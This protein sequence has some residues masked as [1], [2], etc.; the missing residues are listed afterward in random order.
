[1]QRCPLVSFCVVT[2]N[3]ENYIYQ[4]L[5]SIV[6]CNFNFHFEIL[7]GNDKST[8][9]TI[10]EI[11]RF[12]RDFP[13][14]NV[15]LVDRE[16]NVGTNKNYLDLFSKSKGKYF[17][18]LD[19]DDYLEFND[20]SINLNQILLKSNSC[21]A[22][23]YKF[24][25]EVKNEF[26]KVI[27]KDIS[28]EKSLDGLFFHMSSVFFPKWIIDDILNYHW[29]VKYNF[30]DRP[31]QI[32]LI[33]DENKLFFSDTFMSVYRMHINS[34]SKKMNSLEILDNVSHFLIDYYRY[35][36]KRFKNFEKRVFKRRIY[37]NYIL[38][39]NPKNVISF[40][41]YIN[42]LKNDFTV[43]AKSVSYFFALKIVFTSLCL[44]TL[45]KCRF[46]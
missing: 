45:K 37:N 8:D 42:K 30:L 10:N 24:Y 29:I 39:L 18:M 46:N 4:S 19:G 17:L 14:I 32:N 26:E 36:K 11:Q 34:Q 21:V 23:S 43:L 41:S 35:Y 5:H 12:Q 16:I 9:L 31:L 38:I 44:F 28:L 13:E 40:G 2:Y 7:I 15:V 20:D 33:R 3:H 22:F 1:M 6:N 27:I 25:Y